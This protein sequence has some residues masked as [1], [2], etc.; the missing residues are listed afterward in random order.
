MTLRRFELLFTPREGDCLPL[1]DRV[2][3]S[4]LGFEPRTNGLTD[5]YSTTELQGNMRPLRD[6]HSCI[7]ALR[8]TDL[9]YLSKESFAEGWRVELQRLSLVSFQN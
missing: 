6:L 1:A 5:R 7:V 4:S 8:A 3:A 2:L 9:N